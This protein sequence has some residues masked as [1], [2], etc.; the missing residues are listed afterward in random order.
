MKSKILTATTTVKNEAS[1]ALSTAKRSLAAIERIMSVLS[2]NGKLQHCKNETEFLNLL[3][4]HH[5]G[6]QQCIRDAKFWINQL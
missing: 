5:K 6:I 2:S 4:N 1:Y 3:T